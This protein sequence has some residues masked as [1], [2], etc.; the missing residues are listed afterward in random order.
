M[1]DLGNMKMW[2]SVNKTDFFKDY[3]AMVN[4][5]SGEI[6]APLKSNETDFTIFIT[7]VCR[8]DLNF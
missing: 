4:G 7:D 3:C 8:Y 1:T 2:N 6:F 5:S